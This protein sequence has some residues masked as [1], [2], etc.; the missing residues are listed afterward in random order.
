MVKWFKLLVIGSDAFHCDW[1]LAKGAGTLMMQNLQVKPS[2]R[3]CLWRRVQPKRSNF[4]S[5]AQASGAEDKR[6]AA[7]ERIR[8][9]K[10]YRDPSDPQASTSGR[11]AS[12]VQPPA[13]SSAH[14]STKPLQ[15]MESYG[16]SQASQ[17]AEQ[18]LAAVQEIQQPHKA[19]ES[20]LT[21]TGMINS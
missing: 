17:Q 18:L 5:R 14:T 2:C 6:D 9:A 21:P 16:D 15:T 4:I 11:Q 7:A 19:S 1:P 3:H 8:Q 20:D 10:Q 13:Q 12:G